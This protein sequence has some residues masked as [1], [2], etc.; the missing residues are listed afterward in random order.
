M[1]YY[2]KRKICTFFIWKRDP[3][4]KYENVFL[5][6]KK[7]FLFFCSKRVFK[8]KNMSSFALQLVQESY[9]KFRKSL[10]KDNVVSMTM[11]L[12]KQV[13]EYR[14][15]LTGLEKKDL[16]IKALLMMADNIADEDDPKESIIR[17]KLEFTIKSVIPNV[18]DAI[19][20]VDK[21]TIRM[22]PKLSRWWCC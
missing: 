5:F 20:Q 4:F 19:I 11:F 15:E 3:K 8:K 6:K 1:S 14:S 10:N 7:R 18:I 16:V 9:L 12:I 21:Q 22:N 13:E 17:Q 2:E